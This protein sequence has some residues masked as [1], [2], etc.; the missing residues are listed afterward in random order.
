MFL[1]GGTLLIT[2]ALAAAPQLQRDATGVLAPPPAGGIPSMIEVVETQRRNKVIAWTDPDGKFMLFIST[3]KRP[4][5]L[6]IERHGCEPYTA[7]AVRFRTPE[8]TIVPV[9]PCPAAAA[10]GSEQ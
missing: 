10:P 2:G 1:G 9:P 5:T 7:T 4:M 3:R 8:T 6:R